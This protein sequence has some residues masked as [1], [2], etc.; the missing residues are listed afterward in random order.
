MDAGS[1]AP[2][3]PTAPGSTD[4]AALAAST[5][6]A[7]LTAEVAAGTVGFGVAGEG[8]AAS[9]RWPR[10]RSAGCRPVGAWSR[11]GSRRGPR[12]RCCPVRCPGAVGASARCAAR[13][14]AMPSGPRV[15]S[16]PSEGGRGRLSPGSWAAWE[17]RS[18]RPRGSVPP[19]HCRF[20]WLRERARPR[21]S[22]RRV[23]RRVR[24]PRHPAAVAVAPAIVAGAVRGGTR[25]GAGGRGGAGGR[26]GVGRRAGGVDR[27]CARRGGGGAGRAGSGCLLGPRRP[28]PPP[29]GVA[30][31]MT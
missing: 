26:V 12:P 15:P 14:A 19:C 30:V 9:S 23:P 31:G 16:R 13:P 28:T 29:G 1:A 11:A 25:R 3:D 6:P 21:R 24:M 20:R 18:V 5:D 7:G 27:F 2:V 4:A 17:R 8:A 22:R 10:W